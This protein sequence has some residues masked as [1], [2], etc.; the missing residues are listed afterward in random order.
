LLRNKDYNLVLSIDYFT[1]SVLFGLEAYAQSKWIY[2]LILLLLF[3]VSSS[4]MPI[5]R[6]PGEFRTLPME[7]NW[8]LKGKLTGAEGVLDMSSI[9]VAKKM[10]YSPGEDQKSTYYDFMRFWSDGH[11]IL[12]SVKGRPPTLA[13]TEKF[14]YG[15]VGYFV[16][17]KD[18]LIIEVFVPGNYEWEYVIRK[19]M[20]IGDRLIN[21]SDKTETYKKM[22][23]GDMAAQ[24]DW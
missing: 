15:C 23:V 3:F 17:Q 6:I 11:I 12:R 19:Y 18:T 21:L 13:D 7:P 14:S 1:D 10:L 20:I 16:V 2:C 8:K 24:P 4:C 9:Y 22:Y 5:R